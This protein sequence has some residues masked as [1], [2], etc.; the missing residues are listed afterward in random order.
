M[1]SA[2]E[3][4]SIVADVVAARATGG[5]P[6]AARAAAIDAPRTTVRAE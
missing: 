2:A 3:S 5:L 1:P 4:N 6:A